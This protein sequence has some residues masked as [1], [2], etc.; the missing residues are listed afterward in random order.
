MQQIA[1]PTLKQF[2]SYLRGEGFPGGPGECVRALRIYNASPAPQRG[3]RLKTLLAPVFARSA[4][5]QVRFYDAFDAY[6]EEPDAASAP[7]F[8]RYA[9][10]APAV[11]APAIAAPR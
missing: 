7:A 1:E 8:S 6:F 10:D 11:H 9:D 4:A 5:E 2:F 3:D